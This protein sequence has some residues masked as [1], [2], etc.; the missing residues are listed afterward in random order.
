MSPVLLTLLALA[1]AVTLLWLLSLRLRDASIVDIFW[2]CGFV[3]ASVI[4]Y[5]SSEGGR[6]AAIV[7]ALV[8]VWGCRLAIYLAWRNLGRGEDY[9]YQAIRNRYGDSFPVLSLFIVFGFQGLLIWIISMPL[10]IVMARNMPLS[11]VDLI[12]GLL[13]LAGFLFETIG[14]LQ[15][16]RFKADPANRG[17]VMDR[18]LWGYT[19]HP[20]YFGDSLVWWGFYLFAFAAGGW[21]TVFSPILMTLLLL[22]ISGVALLERNLIKTRP[23]YED[24]SRRVSAFIPWKRQR[25]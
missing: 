21:W 18:G 11:P 3:L 16:A 4:A 2:G 7:L 10:Q 13:W 12:A 9:R 17:K 5:L 14:D 15:L 20:N 25:G 24:Y 6:R 19:C 1:A 23:D 22:K 8:T